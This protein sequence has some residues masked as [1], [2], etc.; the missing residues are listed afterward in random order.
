MFP[1]IFHTVLCF[2]LSLSS[3]SPDPWPLISGLRSSSPRTPR[4]QGPTGG[5]WTRSPER[6]WRYGRSRPG[7]RW[8]CS[9][10][11]SDRTL[12]GSWRC[13]Y[14]SS[15]VL[16]PEK[17]GALVVRLVK[18]TGLWLRQTTAEMWQRTAGV[19]HRERLGHDLGLYCRVVHGLQNLELRR[20]EEDHVGQELWRPQHFERLS[21]NE[22]KSER[23]FQT[24]LKPDWLYG[25]VTV[26]ASPCV[27]VSHE[28]KY[29]YV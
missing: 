15:V 5:F 7:C 17:K 8:R 26:K 19:S 29:I 14:M 11:S 25:V 4:W 13:L 24:F 23:C 6:P 12:L 10:R 21:G 18:I 9:G 3:H 22:E 2:Q 1:S 16:H 20:L 27:T 28:P